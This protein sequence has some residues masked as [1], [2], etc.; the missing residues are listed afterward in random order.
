[1]FTDTLLLVNRIRPFLLAAAAGIGAALLTGT[2]VGEGGSFPANLAETEPELLAL[3]WL[4]FLVVTLFSYPPCVSYWRRYRRTIGMT[5]PPVLVVPPIA[6]GLAFYV[7]GLLILHAADVSVWPR[8]SSGI[9]ILLL[10]VGLLLV[11]W[12]AAVMV[13]ARLPEPET[14]KAQPNTDT[15][16]TYSDAPITLDPQDRLGRIPFV[17]RFYDAIDRLPFDE[18][19]V[20][21]LHG[22][23]G[24]V[25]VRF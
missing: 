23:W 16:D 3:V 25:R 8:P 19:F 20:F 6:A 18:P 7:W 21:A 12:V 22:S 2:V 4:F 10:G 9:G 17:Q 11:N 5:R 15:G 1:M 24:K 14:P 13:K